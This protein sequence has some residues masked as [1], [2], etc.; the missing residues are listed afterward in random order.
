MPKK[1][2]SLI[3][4][5]NDLSVQVGEDAYFCRQDAMGVADGVG[6]WCSV[7]N[8]DP[9]LFSRRLLH[10]VSSELEKYDDLLNEEISTQDYYNIDPRKIIQ[11]GLNSLLQET[12]ELVLGSTTV[13][14]G[15]L[16]DEKLKI[17]NI[18][19]CRLLVI[20]GGICVYRT[21]EQVHSFNF[22]FQLGTGSKDSPADAFY[23]EF[24]IQEGDIVIIGTDGLF[25]NV[26]DEDII[27]ITHT[28]SSKA[29]GVCDPFKISTALLQKAREVAEDS[30]QGYSPFQEKAIEE[31]L[32]YH[33]GKMDDITILVGVIHEY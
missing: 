10:H 5:Y 29:R 8:A 27:S 19:D 24:K 17:A 1:K 3:Q 11:Q 18:G 2:N 14:L 22:P 20:R 4:K 7:K 32:Y 21:L 6:G 33:G 16:R 25:D 23:D 28:I 15:I 31:G 26:F 13:L 12:Q 9:A 30:R